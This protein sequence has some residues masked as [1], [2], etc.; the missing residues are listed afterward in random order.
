M[1]ALLASTASYS[2]G[3]GIT[4]SYLAS[5]ITGGPAVAAR[6]AAP[7]LPVPEV[8]TPLPEV[9]PAEA[10]RM[11]A[12]SLISPVEPARAAQLSRPAVD[13]SMQNMQ[14]EA[15]LIALIAARPKR[16]RPVIAAPAEVAPRPVVRTPAPL[17]RL[18]ARLRS[19]HLAVAA[20]L[21]AWCRTLVV[22]LLPARAEVEHRPAAA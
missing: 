10:N 15:A 14:T 18:A 17:A 6:P 4:A 22:S 13:E 1:L 21:V 9:S 16:A 20:A 2:P 8:V 19:L 3:N 7:P 12:R 11:L 5:S